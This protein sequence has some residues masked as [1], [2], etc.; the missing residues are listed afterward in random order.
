M[1]MKLERILIDILIT[2]RFY[3]FRIVIIDKAERRGD[4]GKKTTIFT[5]SVTIS[6][7]ILPYNKQYSSG[8]ILLLKLAYN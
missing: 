4:P 8:S 5:V 2:I 7:Y 6:K 3:F 1:S